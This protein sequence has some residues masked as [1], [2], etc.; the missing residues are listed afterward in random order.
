MLVGRIVRTVGAPALVALLALSL[1][2]CGPGEK[3]AGVATA[4]GGGAG[5]SVTAT[6]T[7]SATGDRDEQLRQFAA[8]MREHGV[9]MPD[10]QPGAAGMAAGLNPSDPQVQSAFTACQATLPG[11]GQPPKL[12]PAQLEQYRAFAACMRDN[13]VDLPDPAADGTLQFNAGSLAQFNTNDP[14]FSKALT[15]CRDT[16][17]GLLASRTGGAS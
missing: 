7:P 13:G 14:A 3:S 4:D 8:C 12:D 17:T 16:L 6:P 10:P 9:D 2:G 5:G 15:A 11:G 1:S